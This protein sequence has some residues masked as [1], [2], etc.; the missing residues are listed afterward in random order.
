MAKSTR[1]ECLIHTILYVTSPANEGVYECF[2]IP[3]GD[4]QYRG[5]HET[6]DKDQAATVTV[7]DQPPDVRRKDVDDRDARR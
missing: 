6:E 5:S 4:G 7:C 3:E 1:L 2:G